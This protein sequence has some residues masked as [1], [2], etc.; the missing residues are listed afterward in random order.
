MLRTVLMSLVLFSPCIPT[1]MA[2]SSRTVGPVTQN[3][4]IVT[5]TFVA[6][7]SPNVVGYNVYRSTT[8]GGPYYKITSKL[9]APNGVYRDIAPMQH[10]TNYYV[11]TSV[12]SSQREGSRSVEIAAV[13]P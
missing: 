5:L 11:M 8:K 1:G 3:P 2:Q 6:S 9:L 4:H 10:S 7:S 12:N 13:V